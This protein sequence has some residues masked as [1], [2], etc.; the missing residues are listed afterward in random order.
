MDDASVEDK[1]IWNILIVTV[2]FFVVAEEFGM[3][4]TFALFGIAF[5]AIGTLILIH[6]EV[7]EIGAHTAHL[8]DP[9]SKNMFESN[10]QKLVW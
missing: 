1:V 6:E 10:L 8:F 9:Q 3:G 7:Q 5:S 4:K 2:L